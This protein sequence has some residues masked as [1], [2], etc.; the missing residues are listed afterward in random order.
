VSSQARY[1]DDRGYVRIGRR[2]EHIIIAEKAFGGPLPKGAIVHHLDGGKENR[3]GN[4]AI[5]PDQAYHLLIHQRMAAKAACGN[6]DWRK[7]PYCQKYDDPANMNHNTGSVKRGRRS[8]GYYSHR[9]CFTK[10][11]KA[12]ACS[13]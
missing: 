3:D 12:K 7:C 11:T 10:Y 5:F 8:N 2:K 13:T 1:I 4:L 9:G 6:P